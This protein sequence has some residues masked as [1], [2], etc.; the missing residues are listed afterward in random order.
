MNHHSPAD[1]APANAL[2]EQVISLVELVEPPTLKVLIVCTGNICRSPLAEQLLRA[3]A[4]ALGVPLAVTSAGTRAML[5]HAMTPEAAALSVQYGSTST[6][7]KPAQ[8]TMSLVIEADLILTA[9]RDHRAEVVSLTPKA[10]RKTFTLMQFARLAPTLVDLLGPP[11]SLV[12]P[13]ETTPERLELLKTLLSKTSEARSLVQPPVA[14]TDDDVVD[15]YKQPQPVYDSV[16][17][18]IDRAATTITQA[19][20]AALKRVK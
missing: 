16:A 17:A 7:H 8:L 5:G 3:K 20:A 6:T 4:Q 19:F 13:V 2:V 12:E 15:P 14:L 11:S 1:P 9:T 18:E 10:I